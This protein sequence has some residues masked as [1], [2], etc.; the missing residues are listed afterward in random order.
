MKRGM[1]TF[2]EKAKLLAS[3]QADLGLVVNNENELVDLPSAREN[4][5]DCNIPIGS[6]RLNDGTF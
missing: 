2:V 3:G 4:T 5:Q 1:C 6:L